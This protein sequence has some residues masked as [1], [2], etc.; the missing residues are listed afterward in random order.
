MD[1]TTAGCIQAKKIQ[2]HKRHKTQAY[3]RLL[4]PPGAV[5]KRSCVCLRHINLLG[6]P[7]MHH[8]S[9]QRFTLR[10]MILLK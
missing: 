8:L 5:L 9:H 10:G 3:K 6:W 1:R 4:A 7:L 2:V